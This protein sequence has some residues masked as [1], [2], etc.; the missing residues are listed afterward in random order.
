MI[1]KTSIQ[2]I[3][4]LLELS[5]LQMGETEGAVR[6]AQRIHVPK[7]Y[8][9]KVL[10]RL[11]RGGI[12]VSK[13]GLNGG[14]RLAKEPSAIRLYDVVAS[15]E[16]VNRWEGCFLNQSIC[17]EETACVMHQHWSKVRRGYINFLKNTTIADLNKI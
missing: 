13:K 14:F 3:K 12:V 11:A 4:A 17:S 1:S 9:G 16:D 8:L 7:N 6:I 2:T 10:Q 5:K 15:F